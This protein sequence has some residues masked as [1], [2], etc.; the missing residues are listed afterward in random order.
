MKNLKKGNKA[1]AIFW[2]LIGSAL[3]IFVWIILKDLF[4][5]SDRVLPSI[6]DVFGSI[7]DFEPN[8]LV[9][10]S[11]TIIRLV[12]GFLGGILFGVSLGIVIYSNKFL[13]RLLTPTIQSFRAVP[14][15][16]T[17]PFFILWFGFSETGRYFMVISGIGFNIA[18]ST[19]QILKF[20]PEKYQIM[21]KS[22][23]KKPSKMI[24]SYMLP[25]IAEDLLPTIRF[26]LSVAIGLVIVSELLGAQ[27]G[28]GY[29]IQTSRSTYSMHVIFLCM[30]LLGL[31][32]F[33]FDKIISS[34]WHKI[35]FW[36]K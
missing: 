32:N 6:K 21:F 3:F 18:V 26:S 13:S 1:I 27:V 20:V 4:H 23:S 16:A 25:R 30:I 22:Y 28:L 5:V 14:P 8:I 36:K 7:D 19:Y 10:S 34:I 15:I 2:T 9:H 12:I 11:S 29:L 17:V 33:T 24:F 35:T 31:I